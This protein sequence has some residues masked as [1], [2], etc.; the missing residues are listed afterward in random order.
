MESGYCIQWDGYS[1]SACSCGPRARWLLVSWDSVRGK[2]E[3]G[4]EGY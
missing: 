1:R 4:G 2:G 3:E